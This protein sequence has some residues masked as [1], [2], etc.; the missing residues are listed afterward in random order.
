MANYFDMEPKN[1]TKESKLIDE[2][3]TKIVP[4]DKVQR[5]V[6]SKPN[7]PLE[8]DEISIEEIEMEN[9]TNMRNRYADISMEIGFDPVEYVDMN[10]ANDKEF[11]T[12]NPL[13]PLMFSED[14]KVIDTVKTALR[15]Q[16]A[17]V[18]FDTGM[19]PMQRAILNGERVELGPPTETVSPLQ[20]ALTAAKSNEAMAFIN[21]LI[22]IENAY[23]KMRN[24][25][26]G[27]IWTLDDALINLKDRNG[28]NIL[29]GKSEN[30]GEY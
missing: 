3:L 18:Y 14:P 10:D 4:K 27:K 2:E 20:K 6:D 30:Q 17:G 13:V 5:N 25:E 8:S 16:K 24:L 1:V 9:K 29:T 7:V 22:A 15:N 12:F 26:I 23:N 19:T 28:N 21:P 11:G